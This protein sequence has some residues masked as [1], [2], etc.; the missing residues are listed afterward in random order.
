[1]EHLK[2]KWALVTG[3]S[4]GIGADFARQLAARGMNVVV[5][6]R[7]LERLNQLKEEIESKYDVEVQPLTADLS[8][9][10][11]ACGMFA[12][13]TEDKALQ[14]F[15][16]NAGIGKFGAFM[17]FQLDDYLKTIE[18][19]ITALTRLT[20]RFVDHALEHGAPAYLGNVAS[21]AAYQTVPRFGVYS[22]TKK[23]VRDLTE[24]LAFEYRKT[25][26]SLTCISPG[27]TWTEFM[28]N[29]GQIVNK[30]A[31]PT[32]MSSKD[33]AK[34][35]LNAMF[36]R[37]P[38]VITGILNKLACLFPRFLPSSWVLAIGHVVFSASVTSDPNAAT[39][40]GPEALPEQTV[41]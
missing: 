14:V 12:K 10:E 36:N 38:A 16:N 25:N 30:S 35:G 39:R 23:Y 1:M 32:M 20:Y 15:I 28:D 5:V 26:V 8:V 29:S 37:K 13:A 41:Q 6:A 34:I 24:T 7:R 2:G 19:N 4:S 31:H 3:A 40:K 9:P 21:I 27:G 11:A 22:G 33:V 18:L 17:D